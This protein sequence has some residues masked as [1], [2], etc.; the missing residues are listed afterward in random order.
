[1]ARK[2]TRAAFESGAVSVAEVEMPSSALYAVMGDA[3]GANEMTYSAEL[4][5]D[6]VREWEPQLGSKI[7]VFFPDKA[8][9]AVVSKG[10]GMDPAAGSAG[11]KPSFAQ[12]SCSLDFLTDPTFF[13]DM[14]LDVKKR[15]PSQLFDPQGDGER[16]A[17]LVI[18]YPSFNVNEMIAVDDAWKAMTK[19]AAARNGEGGAAVV[20]IVIFNGELERIFSG[21]YPPL[22]YRRLSR[23][24][25]AKDG[26]I[27]ASPGSDAT[28]YI[29]NF[30]GLNPGILYRCW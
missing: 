23:V 15:D 5:R 13:G 17:L 29:K 28:Y 26:G 14:G 8:E 4:L 1:M 27:L 11:V 24:A 9:L 21:Y 25:S 30:K 16:D 2:A 19:R 6:F 18:A 7:R 12:T 10:R 20:P 22:F 3:E